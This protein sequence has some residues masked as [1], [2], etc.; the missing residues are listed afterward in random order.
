MPRYNQ[1]QQDATVVMLPQYR[2][3]AVRPYKPGDYTSPSPKAELRQLD[4]PPSLEFQ[5]LTA[6]ENY[7]RGHDFF[8]EQFD[9][10]G[11]TDAAADA[12]DFYDTEL[13]LE[14]PALAAVGS[15]LAGEAFDFWRDAATD[16]INIATAGMGA[17]PKAIVGSGVMKKFPRKLTDYP[18]E[19]FIV[20]KDDIAHLASGVGRPDKAVHLSPGPLP[21]MQK[22]ALGV[23]RFD[24]RVSH[25]IP[26]PYRPIT[27]EA[28]AAAD[29]P[30]PWPLG[31]VPHSGD[32]GRGMVRRYTNTPVYDGPLFKGSQAGHTPKPI[33]GEFG[34]EAAGTVITAWYGPGVYG[35]SDADHALYYAEDGNM[36]FLERLYQPGP[37]NVLQN[38]RTFA[39]IESPVMREKLMTLFGPGIAEPTGG[40]YRRIH[41]YIQS[42]NAENPVEFYKELRELG[43]EE[44]MHIDHDQLGSTSS[45]VLGRFHPDPID[46]E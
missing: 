19:A 5:L 3:S 42:A 11:I 22:E 14:H 1:P 40:R 6:G 23:A 18:K 32:I 9:R 24:P 25:L 7:G 21:G 44:L 30:G 10:T 36:H 39:D 29:I 38:W 45:A 20:T 17:A 46:P 13:Y 28:A 35:S 16:P 2:E 26:T 34:S 31:E 33:T 4:R 43:I 8:K 37:E 41:D 12:R 15:T 27:D